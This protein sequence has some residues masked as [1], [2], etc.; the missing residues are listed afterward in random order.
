MIRINSSFENPRFNLVKNSKKVEPI[1]QSS[2]TNKDN[3]EDKQQKYSFQEGVIYERSF[4]Q[5]LKEE[6]KKK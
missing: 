6:I 3:K 2:K 1:Y 5:L 4:D